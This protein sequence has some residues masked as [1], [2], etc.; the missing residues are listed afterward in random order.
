LRSPV[1]IVGPLVPILDGLVGQ[2]ALAPGHDR[3][4]RV[5]TARIL[6]ATHPRSRA[7]FVR[8]LERVDARPALAHLDVPTLV[9]AGAQDRVTPPVR[10]REIAATLPDARLHV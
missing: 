2:F 5:K 10:S 6:R 9:I 1:P 7:A 3:A 8:F 4:D